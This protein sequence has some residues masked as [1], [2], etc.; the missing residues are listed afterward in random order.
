MQRCLGEEEE[1]EEEEEIKKKRKERKKKQEGEE[2]SKKKKKKKRRRRTEEEGREE[3]V[4]IAMA[5]DYNQSIHSV[6][7][8]FAFGSR[9]LSSYLKFYL[10]SDDFRLK[11]VRYTREAPKKRISAPSRFESLFI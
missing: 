2:E 7:N 8:I 10:K 5:L 4:A 3:E 11:L 1:K 6:I 9:L